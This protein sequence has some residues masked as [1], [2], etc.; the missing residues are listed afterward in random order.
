MDGDRLDVREMEVERSI[1]FVGLDDREG[2]TVHLSLDGK[3]YFSGPFH[4][5][6]LSALSLLNLGP[7]QKHR[8][9]CITRNE[10]EGDGGS[11]NLCIS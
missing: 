1:T 9:S 10:E 11:P 3:S 4:T 8:D 7:P 6:I 2:D 5:L